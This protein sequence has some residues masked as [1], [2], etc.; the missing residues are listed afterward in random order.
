MIIM[1]LARKRHGSILKM[2][3]K[4]L[5]FS[6]SFFLVCFVFFSTLHAE[7]N[8]VVVSATGRITVKPDMA[9]FGVVVKSDA[10]T[11]AEAAAE[12]AGK[13][14]SVQNSLRAVGIS[15]DN[16]PTSGYTVAPRSEWDPSLGKS[17]LKGYSARHTIMV[18]VR[19]LENIGRAVD[20]VVQ[21]GADEVQSISFSSSHYDTLRQEAL[22][23]AVENARRDAGVMAKAAGG[24][25]GQLME[26][27]VNHP[28]FRDQPQMEALAMRA[29]PAPVPTELAP[30]EQVITVTV[31]S[32]WLFIPTSAR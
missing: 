15:L 13:Y 20:A 4:R 11:A 32:R 16:A 8:Q 28:S 12:T 21:A 3:K 31:S 9:E 6:L 5:V 2:I 14:R 29:A 26:V 22:A 18:R 25:I 27:S 19:M 7:E 1:V 17:V 24:R 10:K 30:N 23:A